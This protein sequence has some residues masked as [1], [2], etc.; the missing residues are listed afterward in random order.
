M[1]EKGIFSLALLLA[2][3][4]IYFSIIQQSLNNEAL[5]QKAVIQTIK[6]EKADFIR[7]EIEINV[8]KIIIETVKD[9]LILGN[10][11]PFIIKM[12]IAENLLYYFNE[13]SN[14]KDNISCFI[15]D[16]T[17]KEKRKI[18][19][20]EISDLISVNLNE[21]YDFL[22]EVTMHAG[23]LKNLEPSCEINFGDVAAFFKIKTDYTIWV[24]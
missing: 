13:I 16:K 7:S 20:K 2:F 22:V 18:N 19:Q 24:N 1:N 6:A 21:G 10:K 15:Y 23:L 9:S 4:T 14:T 11:D 3:C 8:E 12:Q 5:L 17:A